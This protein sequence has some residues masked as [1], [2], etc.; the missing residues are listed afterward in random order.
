MY[1]TTS[2][3]S[4]LS[5]KRR[6]ANNRI[7]WKKYINLINEGSGTNGGPGSFVTLNRVAF[8]IS[9]FFRFS[10]NFSMVF[11]KNV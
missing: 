3:Y 5:N 8:E 6:V 2:Y 11:Y 10:T 7:V 1:D 9:N 4:Y